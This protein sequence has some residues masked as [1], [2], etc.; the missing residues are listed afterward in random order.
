MSSIINKHSHNSI[1]LITQGRGFLNIIYLLTLWS[2]LGVLL[3]IIYDHI[4]K[5]P[6]C[7]A[8]GDGHKSTSNS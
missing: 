3:R 2:S 5:K 8:L 6:H 7:G 4:I 1:N